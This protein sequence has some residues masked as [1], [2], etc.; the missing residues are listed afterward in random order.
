[1]SRREL[2][3]GSF[4]HLTGLESGLMVPEASYCIEQLLTLSD[5]NT[6]YKVRHEAEP[7]DRIVRERDLRT[8]LAKP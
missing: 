7:F 3:V 6:L 2:D 5:G 1:M 4:V 8:S